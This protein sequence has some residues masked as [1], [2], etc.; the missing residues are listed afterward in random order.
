MFCNNIKENSTESICILAVPTNQE[1]PITNSPNLTATGRLIGT[2][3]L[4]EKPAAASRLDDII[5]QPNSNQ[6][7]Y[8]SQYYN[9]TDG[10]R[11]D[12]T[13]NVEIKPRR[14][15]SS[16]SSSS[17]S[18]STSS[19][20][21]AKPPLTTTNNTGLPPRNLNRHQSLESI[22][23]RTSQTERTLDPTNKTASLEF[24]QRPGTFDD[25]GSIYITPQEAAHPAS[26]YQ[27]AIKG[28]IRKQNRGK[29]FSTVKRIK[30]SNISFDT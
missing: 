26:Q 17:S 23:R 13:T 6:E 29:L 9:I 2:V 7:S 20:G 24:G 16:S 21:P 1:Q 14:T 10:R 15:L 22:P 4:V 28:W 27:N 30:R 19:T 18:T 3:P 12:S 8:P 11:Y 25:P 5:H